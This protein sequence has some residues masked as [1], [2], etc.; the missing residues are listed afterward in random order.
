MVQTDH[1]LHYVIRSMILANVLPDRNIT[2][3]VNTSNIEL[4][5]CE[6]NGGYVLD[7]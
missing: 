1:I 4:Y 7:V 2:E 6:L 5:I 3:L